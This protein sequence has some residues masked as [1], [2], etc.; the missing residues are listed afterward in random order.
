MGVR[1]NDDGRHNEESLPVPIQ[2][3]DLY[4]ELFGQIAQIPAPH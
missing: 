4:I 2:W 1:K 3:E